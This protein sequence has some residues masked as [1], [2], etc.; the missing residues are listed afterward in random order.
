VNGV[1]GGAFGTGDSQRN[2]S[3]PGLAAT[4]SGRP[5]NSQALGAVEAGYTMAH[6]DNISLTPFASMNVG[7]VN[8]H[9]FSET[10]AGTLNLTVAAQTITAAQ[11]VLGTRAGADLALGSLVLNTDIKLGWGHEFSTARRI[12]QAFA[13]SPNF[14]VAG[15]SL[16][17][18]SAVVGASVAATLDDGLSAY[19]HYDGA[20]AGG[21][22]SSTVSAG[23][24][25]GW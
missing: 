24:R 12:I 11:S 2:V 25:F 18:D 3:L 19:L 6:G 23:I 5:G 9:A 13:G 21:E 22:S 20:F 10:G 16:P 1:A 17:G 15:A 8:Q 4:A 7:S 14:T